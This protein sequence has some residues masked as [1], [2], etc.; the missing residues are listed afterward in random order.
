MLF[1]C[2]IVKVVVVVFQFLS[3]FVSFMELSGFT[4]S[5]RGSL[6]SILPHHSI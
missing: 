6:H 2:N 3:G 5:F 1:T 4:H